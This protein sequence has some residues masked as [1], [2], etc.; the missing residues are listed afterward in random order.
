MAKLIIDSIEAFEKAVATSARTA[1]LFKASWD[2]SSVILANEL[3]SNGAFSSDESVQVAVLD[4]GDDDV[5]S[6]ALDLGVS[7]PG[8]AMLYRSG[9]KVSMLAPA[10]KKNLAQA[11]EDL[12]QGT[13]QKSKRHN[14]CIA[15]LAKSRVHAYK[16]THINLPFKSCAHAIRLVPFT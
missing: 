4:L 11:L 7:V 12:K 2:N 8:T 13:T 16:S 1:F 9:V 15:R 14:I 10:T 6:F 5:A 3:E